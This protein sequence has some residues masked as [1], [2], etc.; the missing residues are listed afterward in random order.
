[1]VVYHFYPD[2]E[3][4]AV[5]NIKSPS[6]FR[7]RLGSARGDGRRA[8]HYERTDPAALPFPCAVE[9]ATMWPSL[10]KVGAS[11]LKKASRPGEN[12][13]EAATWRPIP[14]CRPQRHPAPCSVVETARREA[15]I[16]AGH[17][18]RSWLVPGARLATKVA[19]SADVDVI[20]TSGPPHTV[21][22]AGLV[23]SWVTGRPLVSDFRDPWTTGEPPETGLE[24]F[25]LRIDRWLESLVLRR[26]QLVL[27]ATPGRP[28]PGHRGVPPAAGYEVRGAHQRVRPGRFPCASIQA[29]WSCRGGCCRSCSPAPS[30]AAEAPSP[31]WLRSA[32]CW[33]KACSTGLPSGWISTAPLKSTPRPPKRP[34]TAYS[35]HDV[36]SF[37]PAVNRQEYLGLIG[38]ADVLI[39]LQG[40]CSPWALPAK[41][42]DYLATGNEILLISGPHALAKFLEPFDSVHLADPHDVA[43]IKACIARI[44]GPA[45]LGARPTGGATWSPSGGLHKRELTGEFARLLDTVVSQGPGNGGK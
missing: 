13:P 42:F 36:V 23:A 7:V 21:H 9:R 35:L 15:G 2:L 37:R 33:R 11:L 3:V 43:G 32:R 10:V 26:S 12:R 19:R 40:E 27:A 1:M 45:P 24:R 22:L 25:F 16:N 34:S 17:S 38:G 20:Y 18:C 41:N 6:T 29:G 5:R 4:G 31:S 28:G 44:A 30:T 8:R 39:L 14:A